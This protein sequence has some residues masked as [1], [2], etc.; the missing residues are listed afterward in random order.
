MHVGFHAVPV[1]DQPELG[2]CR[3]EKLRTGYLLPRLKSV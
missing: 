1:A 2:A 3:T